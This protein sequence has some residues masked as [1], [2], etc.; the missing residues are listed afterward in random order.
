MLEAT[1]FPLS[2]QLILFCVKPIPLSG[3]ALIQYQAE[4]NEE[5]GLL[6]LYRSDVVLLPGVDTDDLEEQKYLICRGLQEFRFT[7]LIR[8]V[9]KLKIGK[10]KEV[11]VPTS[12]GDAFGEW[13]FPSL[14]SVELKFAE[15]VESDNSTVFKT[16]VALP[17]FWRKQG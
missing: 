17:Q 8:M 3:H 6:D 14:V 7:Y 9:M 5:T 12:E 10:S 1:V 11:V 13:P 16:A 4:L 2:H 15:S